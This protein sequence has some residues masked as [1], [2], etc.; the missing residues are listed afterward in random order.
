MGF[1]LKFYVM[2]SPEIDL[3]GIVHVKVDF[4]EVLKLYVLVILRRFVWTTWFEQCVLLIPFPIFVVKISRKIWA[5]NGNFFA[6]ANCVFDFC[7]VPNYRLPLKFANQN[8]I[9][10]GKSPKNLKSRIFRLIFLQISM[11][12]YTGFTIFKRYTPITR[13]FAFLLKT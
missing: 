2:S 3:Y 8:S 6:L 9:S 13:N 1:F 7:S 10:A 11:Y 12:R 4:I 5:A